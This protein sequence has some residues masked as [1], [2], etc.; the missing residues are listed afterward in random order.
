[1]NVTKKLQSGQ[2]IKSRGGRYARL[3]RCVQH[4]KVRLKG[5]WFRMEHPHP[6]GALLSYWPFREAEILGWGVRLLKNQPSKA[7]MRKAAV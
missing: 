3:V 7:A 4:N 5:R 6:A 2:W 1:M